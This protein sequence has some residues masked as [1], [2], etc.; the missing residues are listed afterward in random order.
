MTLLR[1]SNRMHMRPFAELSISALTLGTV[2]LGLRYGIANTTGQPSYAVARDIIACAVEGGVN[3]LDTAVGYGES[4]QM[5][6][7]ALAELGLADRVV[8][9]TKIPPMADDFSSVAAVDAFIEEHVTGS[10]ARLGLDVLPLCMF[11]LETNARYMESLLKLQ[12]RGLVRHVGV[13]MMTPDACAA[14][15]ATGRAEAL[16]V[17]TSVLDQRFI[18]RGLLRDAAT[19]GIA[20]FVRSIYL[21]GLLLLAEEHI[22]PE[23]AEVIPVRRRL[24]TLARGGGMPLTEL[25]L[26][27]ALGLD[28]ATS[29]VVGMETVAQ[30]RENLTLAVRGPLPADLHRAALD[31]VP[32]LSEQILSPRNW[33]QRMPDSVP[34]KR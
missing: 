5:I 8:I 12:E 1:V 30:V 18:R 13:S 17:P 11:H 26:R 31:A 20:L 27:F 34:A 14:H 33:T 6:G 23:L 4:E 3:C 28:G 29:I 22:Q 15:I 24:E 16:Q 19:A 7:R 9:V 25:A 2:Q 10:L 21:Q 32:A